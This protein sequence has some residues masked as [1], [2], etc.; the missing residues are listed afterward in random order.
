MATCMTSEANVA[1]LDSVK[2]VFNYF[3]FL[4]SLISLAC[5]ET[6]CWLGLH[7]KMHPGKK[8]CSVPMGKAVF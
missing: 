7:T 5:W 8:L 6:I 2:E 4:H 3:L 1:L